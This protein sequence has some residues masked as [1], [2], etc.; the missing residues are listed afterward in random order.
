MN[1]RPRRPVNF[2]A[3]CKIDPRDALLE[4]LNSNA[5]GKQV[6]LPVVIHYQ[7]AY[8]LAIARAFIGKSTEDHASDCIQL[9]LDTSF[10]GIPLLSQLSYRAPEGVIAVGVW[11]EGYWGTMP[12]GF[13]DLPDGEFPF[14]VVRVGELMTGQATEQTVFIEA[15]T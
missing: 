15:D 14:Q 10:M 2:K 12:L 8:Q 13:D 9:W 7:D 3:G 11:L 6:K 1:K 5:T 4:W